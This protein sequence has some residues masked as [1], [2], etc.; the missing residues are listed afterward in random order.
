VRNGERPETKKSVE[1]VGW[2]ATIAAGS[3]GVVHLSWNKAHVGDALFAHILNGG[4]FDIT[5][6][7]EWFDVFEKK[8]PMVIFLEQ[9]ERIERSER[10]YKPARSG[11]MTPYNADEK[12]YPYEYDRKQRTEKPSRLR[13]A[14]EKLTNL[15]D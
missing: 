7:V 12:G 10:I 4:D 6:R 5:A 15:L 8:I 2:G 14:F 3:T 9:N 1:G 11:L 13:R